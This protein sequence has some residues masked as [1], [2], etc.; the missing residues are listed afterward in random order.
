M[1]KKALLKAGITAGSVF[2]GIY[3]VFLLCPLVLNPI[4]NGYTPQI[5]N[6][7]HKASGLDAKL[8]GVKLVTTPKLTAG[9][10]VGKFALLTPDNEQIFNADDFQVKMSL[11][12]ILARRIEIDAVQ[13][14][15]AE[16]SLKINKDGSFDIEQ[17]F[18]KNK[19]DSA[20][21]AEAETDETPANTEPF[22]LP[23]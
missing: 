21:T 19:E 3:A 12:P 18:P 10:K 9:L 17:Y 8:E 2:I 4:I 13:L 20:E 14:K 15:N 22:S 11:I 1:N 6:E 5:V 16:L 7:I 23:F